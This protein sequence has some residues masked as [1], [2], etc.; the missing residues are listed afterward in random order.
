MGE[1]TPWICHRRKDSATSRIRGQNRAPDPGTPSPGA[2]RKWLRATPRPAGTPSSCSAASASWITQNPLMPLVTP[3]AASASWTTQIPYS[4]W[5]PLCRLLDNTNPV[6]PVVTPHAASASW[7]TRIPLCQLSPPYATSASWQHKSPYARCH[8]L[9]LVRLLMPLCHP[10]CQ[11]CHLAPYADC[12]ARSPHSCFAAVALCT[13]QNHGMPVMPYATLHLMPIVVQGV[14]AIDLPP[15]P[16]GQQ[17]PLCR[18]YLMLLATVIAYAPMICKDSKQMFCRLRP[19]YKQ[20]PLMPIDAFY[21]M[22]IVVQ[23]V[24]TLLLPSSPS[25][26]A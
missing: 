20:K 11:L 1:V 5:H 23:E 26:T 16:P 3:Y 8:P 7:T 4:S 18:L 24:L 9:C 22:P 2:G 10:F 19:L 15:C 17:N 21:H 6:M 14:Q 13:N 25:C 12:R